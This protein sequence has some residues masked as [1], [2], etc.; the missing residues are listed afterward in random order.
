MR[1]LAVLRSRR[2]SQFSGIE[3]IERYVQPLGEM[4]KL[5]FCDTRHCFPMKLLSQ[6]ET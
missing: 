3:S 6:G 5:R 1:N 2:V 4:Q